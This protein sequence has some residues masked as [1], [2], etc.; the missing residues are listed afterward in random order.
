[1]GV[2]RL[3]LDLRNIVASCHNK[4]S[5]SI[6]LVFKGIK[7]IIMEYQ[8]IYQCIINGQFSIIH[9]LYNHIPKSIDECLRPEYT[10]GSCDYN[11]SYFISLIQSV[12]VYILCIFC[13]ANAMHIKHVNTQHTTHKHHIDEWLKTVPVLPRGRGYYESSC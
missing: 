7:D 8:F 10:I 4:L 13:I 9:I 5:S 1:M 11:I 2:N 12:I 6:S 3:L